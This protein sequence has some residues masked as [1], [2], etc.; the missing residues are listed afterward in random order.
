MARQPKFS[1]LLSRDELAGAVKRL[2]GEIR[3]DYEG[4]HPLFVAVLKGSF[5][6]LADLVR[7]ID[8]PLTLTFVEAR[9]YQGST[10]T[11]KVRLVRGMDTGVRG[12]HVV[13]VEDV[14]DTGA[15]ATYL[16]KRIRRM[17][18]TSL[19][20]CAL[21]D[22]PSL[23]RVPVQ[24]DYLGYTVPNRFL[25]GYGLDL[26]EGYRHLPDIYALDEEEEGLV[27][28]QGFP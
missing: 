16:I 24:I 12:S 13:L 20:L 25:V 21:L 10:S 7:E 2:A 17:Q 11:G 18:P 8:I 5:V 22:K 19:R 4:K 6:F 28:H 15:T 1:L 3:R 9:S 23:R 26:D 14:V 27:G